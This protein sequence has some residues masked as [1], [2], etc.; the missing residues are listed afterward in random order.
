MHTVIGVDEAGRGPL[1]GPVAVGLIAVPTGFNILAAFPGLGDS[2]LLSEEMRDELYAKLRE[3]VAK[4]KLQ[5]SVQF[6]S[7]KMID[8]RGM[9]RAIAGAIER[10]VRELRPSPAGVHI[11]LDGLLKAPAE[12]RQQTI[13]GGDEHVPVIALASIAAKVRRDRLMKRFAKQF[14]AYG[15][16][17]H[18]GY[19]TA[20]HKEA[21]L[22]V[23]PC[24]IHRRSFLRRILT[25]VV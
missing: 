17:L 22:S 13:I 14:P 1:A 5:F 10:G 18:K 12:Y 23:G 15:F 19:G 11:L 6:S 4:G 3:H 16:E 21:L 2:K 8:S 9:T 24:D 20:R 25:D 7:A